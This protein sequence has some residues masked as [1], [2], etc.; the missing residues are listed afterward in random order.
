MKR[1]ITTIFATALLGFSTTIVASPIY[2]YESAS[3]NAFGGRSGG[4]YDSI[5]LS[6]DHGTQ[7]F[8]FTVDYDGAV[9]AG[10][11]LV[12]SEGPNPK[13][14]DDELAILYFDRASQDV[15]AYAY[16]GR[17]NSA[18]YETTSFLGYFDNAY[19][20]AGDVS[21]L[22]LNAAG[23]NGMLN[24]SGLAFGPGIGIWFH[25]AFQQIVEGDETGLYYYQTRQV[26]WYDTHNDG[27]KCNNQRGHGGCVTAEV[28]EPAGI[29]LLVSGLAGLFAARRRRIA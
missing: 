9:A 7:D 5:S 17:N 2:H 10:G 25:P 4:G 20:T 6:Y 3:S 14:A 16:N 19:T 26:G 12:V 1:R 15:W 29:A 8:S 23:I 11:W 28:P 21:T 18:S 13:R 22:A 24:G 27:G